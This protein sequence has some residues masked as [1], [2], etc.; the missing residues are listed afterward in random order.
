VARMREFVNGS[1]RK[2]CPEARQGEM[3]PDRMVLHAFDHHGG[4]AG[5]TKFVEAGQCSEQGVA[6]SVEVQPV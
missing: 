1:V 5:L 4:D 2:E 6:D 3:G